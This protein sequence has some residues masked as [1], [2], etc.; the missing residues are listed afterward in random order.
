MK[1][2]RWRSFV[3]AARITYPNPGREGKQKKKKLLYSSGANMR[4]HRAYP[5]NIV[6]IP[7]TSSCLASDD[8]FPS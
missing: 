7:F 4:V 2:L 1:T 6:H 3:M 5:L 8:T